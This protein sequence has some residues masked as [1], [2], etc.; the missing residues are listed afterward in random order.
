MANSGD[1]SRARQIEGGLI[2]KLG[3]LILDSGAQALY[4]QHAAHALHRARIPLI[5]GLL[6]RLNIVL[7]GAD[8]HPAARIGR[9]VSFIH[10]VGIVIGKGAEVGDDC[11]IYGGVVL[12]GLGGGRGEDGFPRIGKNS[13]L[14]VGAKILGPITIGRDS[15]VAAGA[16]VLSSVPA[17][18]LAAGV[19]ATVRRER[20]VS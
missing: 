17:G 9:N 8:L 4:L 2:R 3:R 11:D 6:R 20:I 12:G 7:T 1:L 19:P 15:T 16:V 18:A 13:V 5:P 10:S 14:C